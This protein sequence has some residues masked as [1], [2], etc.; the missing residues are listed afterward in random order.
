MT[1]VVITKDELDNF[2]NE[3]LGKGET[4]NEQPSVIYSGKLRGVVGTFRYVPSI[5]SVV[6]NDEV[7]KKL[8]VKPKKVK[9]AP[10]KV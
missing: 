2:S 7:C 1:A 6:V 3:V 5:N 9:K 8:G 4:F 10:N